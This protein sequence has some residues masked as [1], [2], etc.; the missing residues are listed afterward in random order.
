MVTDVR[1]AGPQ[2]SR[3]TTR[4]LNERNAATSSWRRPVILPVAPMRR[5][6]PNHRL[7]D[8]VSD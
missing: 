3:W 1:S 2:E 7:E 4:D 6:R 5:Y 8:D